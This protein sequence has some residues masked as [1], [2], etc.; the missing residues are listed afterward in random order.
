MSAVLIAILTKVAPAIIG[1]VVTWA[2]KWLLGKF[3]TKIPALAKIAISAAAGA[4]TAVTTGDTSSITATAGE[5][6]A[7]GLMGA[8]GAKARDVATGNTEV[9]T[10]EE[11]EACDSVPPA[12]P[13]MGDT[14]TNEG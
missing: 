2:V 7:G 3:D 13:W 11:K 8:G 14:G 10:K 1:P 4:V 6:L 5:V 9:A 12:H